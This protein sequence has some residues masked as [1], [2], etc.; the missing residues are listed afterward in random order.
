MLYFIFAGL[1]VLLDRLFKLW[2]ARTLDPGQ[3]IEL[4]PGIL[5]L[6]HTENTGAAFSILSDMRWLLVT[7][8][9]AAVLAL[10]LMIIFY[11]RDGFARF[12]TASILGGA[13]GNL[14]D[15]I[16]TGRVIDM[17]EPLFVNFAVFNVADVFIVLGGVALLIH[18]LIPSGTRP[19]DAGQRKSPV[20]AMERTLA[21]DILADIPDTPPDTQTDTRELAEELTEERI[22]EEYYRDLA[23]G[24]N[25]GGNDSSRSSNSNEKPDNSGDNGA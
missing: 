24:Q 20:V 6:T 9:S 17:F 22:L 14:I 1:I 12:A 11:K 7:L 10:V 2:I 18:T 13:V 19:R 21:D 23:A 4:I 15:R 3:V 25:G 5:R 8:S 16:D